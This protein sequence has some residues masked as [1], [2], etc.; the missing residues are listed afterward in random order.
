MIIW[1]LE[2]IISMFNTTKR[3][4]DF[5]AGTKLVDS[6]IEEPELIMNEIYEKRNIEN[7][8]KLIWTSILIALTFN[9]LS[10][11]PI[12]LTLI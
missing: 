12:L 1:P 7:K 8:S 2:V 11:L 5:V 10:A 6:D 3:L 4:G 9:I